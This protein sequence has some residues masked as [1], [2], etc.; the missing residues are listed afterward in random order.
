MTDLIKNCIICVSG[1]A[2]IGCFITINKLEDNHKL[3]VKNITLETRLSKL[4]AFI[5]TLELS[6]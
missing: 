6:E 1:L 4:E 5:N 3:Y 2:I